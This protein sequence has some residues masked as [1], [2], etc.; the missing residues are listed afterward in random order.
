MINEAYETASDIS[1]F[2]E[3]FYVNCSMQ[4]KLKL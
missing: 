4:L 1:D 3:E 2:V